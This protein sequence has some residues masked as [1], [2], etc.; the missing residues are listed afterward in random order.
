MLQCKQL[1]YTVRD[2]PQFFTSFYYKMSYKS[3][4]KWRETY[5]SIKHDLHLV[6]IKQKKNKVVLSF[7]QRV[8]TA[9][10]QQEGGHSTVLCCR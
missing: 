4:F 8:V 5:L 10:V 1:L 9:A 6:S 3:Y 7:C 2:I